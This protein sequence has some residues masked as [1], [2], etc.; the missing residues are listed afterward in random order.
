MNASYLVRLA[1]AALP[2][3][4]LQAKSADFSFSGHLTYNTD[5][6]QV[7]FTLDLDASHVRLWTDSWQSGLNFDPTL[8]LWA[9]QGT[10][11]GLVGDNDDESSLDPGQGFYDSGLSL[12]ALAAGQY[13]LTLGAAPNYASGSLLSNGFAFDGTAPILIPQWNQPSYDINAND[14][15]GSFWQLNLS[16]VD[17]AA[18]VPEPSG[19]SL[20]L[21]G[22]GVMLTVARRRA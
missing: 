10:G 19:L 8:T 1:A 13:L 2:L 9:K 4:A 5:V 16:G 12:S 20:V 11:Y 14:Q 22:M 18:A 6:V 7:A 3:F 17:S 21:A 15:K